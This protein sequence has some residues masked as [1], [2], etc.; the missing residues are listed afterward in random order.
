MSMTDLIR[1]IDAHL[2]ADRRTRDWVYKLVNL[3][4]GARDCI[5][6]LEAA[7]AERKAQVPREPTEAMIR[8]GNYLY[9]AR[10]CITTWRAM[11]DAA[12]AARQPAA[13]GESE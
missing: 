6:D 2:K 3:T 13:G 11:Y 10:N 1:E 4:F 8:A 5:A 9:P 7:L 12:L